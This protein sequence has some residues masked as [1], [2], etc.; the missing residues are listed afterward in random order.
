MVTQQTYR[1]MHD[2][3]LEHVKHKSDK[4]MNYFLVGFFITGLLL[5]FFYDTW[6]VAIGVG[7]L[8]LLAYYSTRLLLAR[9]NAY[10]YIVSVVLGLYMAQF[11]YQMHGLDR[12]SVV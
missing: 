8:S 9:S 1:A 4:L 2:A 3:Y 10:Q 12:K 11:I 6:L 7:S 5:A